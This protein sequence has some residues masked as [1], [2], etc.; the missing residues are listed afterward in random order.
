MGVV[1]LAMANSPQ[2]DQLRNTFKAQVDSL[3]TWSNAK[4]MHPTFK[5]EIDAL[6]AKFTDEMATLQA[7]SKAAEDTKT[8]CNFDRND[9]KGKLFMLAEAV[10]HET[11]ESQAEMEGIQARQAV[12]EQEIVQTIE[13]IATVRSDT[14]LI[15]E[16]GDEART[17]CIAA[18]EDAT[19]AHAAEIVEIK[20]AQ[21]AAQAEIEDT[22]TT[23]SA[24]EKRFNEIDIALNADH[25]GN[26]LNLTNELNEIQDRT[27]VI[28]GDTNQMDLDHAAAKGEID[29]R[30]NE[31]E[32][33]VRHKQDLHDGA[34]RDQKVKA[35][36]QAER[37]RQLKMFPEMIADYKRSED[38]II[39][40]EYD[41]METDQLISEMRRKHYLGT[42]N[43]KEKLFYLEKELER[44]RSHNYRISNRIAYSLRDPMGI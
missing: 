36:E 22:R 25:M 9:P 2:N 7:R 40:L 21:M 1:L 27:V 28:Q 31:V 4:D 17:L 38:E 41:V 12:I 24:N 18:G 37:I 29:L 10:K 35:T 19:T 42:S 43:H 23:C 34:C 13:S 44:A 15:I 26:M 16:A 14:E 20:T 11:S 30:C 6:Y 5:S 39:K 32:A 8:A 3:Q 33:G